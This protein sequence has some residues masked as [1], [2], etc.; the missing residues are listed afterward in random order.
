MMVVVQEEVP[1][2]DKEKEG[3]RK[4]KLL[5]TPGRA[6]TTAEIEKKKEEE[7]IRP[8]VRI[9]LTLPSEKNVAQIVLVKEKVIVHRFVRKYDSIYKNSFTIK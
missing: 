6:K 1:K 2:E 8:S 9:T 7:T 5:S 4:A 3:K